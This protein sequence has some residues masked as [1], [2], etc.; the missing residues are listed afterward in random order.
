[1]SDQYLSSGQEST[2]SN[3]WMLMRKIQSQRLDHID[4]MLADRIFEFIAQQIDK[5]VRWLH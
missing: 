5:T 2:L 4:T 3:F 1:M